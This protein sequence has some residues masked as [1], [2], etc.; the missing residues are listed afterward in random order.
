MDI[1][2]NIVRIR[3]RRGLSQ[4]ALAA[5]VGFANTYLCQIEHGRVPP[6]KTLERIA[7]ALGV[8]LATLVRRER[9]R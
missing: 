2:R 9:Q 7:E 6:V 1:G 8:S 3:E 4:R 5:R